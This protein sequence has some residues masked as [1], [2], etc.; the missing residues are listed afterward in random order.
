MWSVQL[1][2]ILGE[3]WSTSEGRLRP[4]SRYRSGV[5]VDFRLSFGGQRPGPWSEAQ[6]RAEFEKAL[7]LARSSD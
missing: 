1:K 4:G 2:G 5:S 3:G 6:K 7:A